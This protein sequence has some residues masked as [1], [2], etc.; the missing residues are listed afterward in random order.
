MITI[1]CIPSKKASYEAVIQSEPKLKRRGT[2][3]VASEAEMDKEQR[4][5][6]HSVGA[7]SEAANQTG[8]ETRERSTRHSVANQTGKETRERSTRHSVA[9]HTGKE[10]RER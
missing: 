10:T 3:D 1:E 8:K 7:S 5:R 2:S 4:C 6:M 9:I